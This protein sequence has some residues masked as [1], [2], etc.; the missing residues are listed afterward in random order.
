M[1]KIIVRCCFT[2][3]S[4]KAV[5]KKWVN[6]RNYE[7]LVFCAQRRN[8]ANKVVFQL[9]LFILNNQNQ[10]SKKKI[11]SQ[12]CSEQHFFVRHFQFM[13]HGVFSI[14]GRGGWEHKQLC[15]SLFSGP[16]FMRRI[17][18]HKGQIAFSAP[19]QLGTPIPTASWTSFCCG[20]FFGIA[21]TLSCFLVW[22][23]QL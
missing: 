19:L 7:S 1:D 10:L 21:L 6:H 20:C 15:I 22:I 23:F 8:E 16:W 14:K 18:S 11:I 9:P 2:M 13:Y 5:E 17:A 3:D 4:T 12:W